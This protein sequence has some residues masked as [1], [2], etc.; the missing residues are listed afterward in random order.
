MPENM[1]RLH[2]DFPSAYLWRGFAEASRKEYDKADA[3]FQTAL[4]KDPNNSAAY[5]ALGQI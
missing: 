4:K 1:I 3:D 5:L 2:P